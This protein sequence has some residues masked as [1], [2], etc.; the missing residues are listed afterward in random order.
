MAHL[1][2]DFMNETVND[3]QMEIDETSDDYWM[4]ILRFGE[5]WFWYEIVVKAFWMLLL[6]LAALDLLAFVFNETGLGYGEQAVMA[7]M[8]I[9]AG[10]LFAW[11][12]FTLIKLLGAWMFK[13]GWD[14][15]HR[16]ERFWK[17]RLKNVR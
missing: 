10:V 4:N 6:W 8:V 12:A 11:F 3:F 15:Y 5:T 2:R 16:E 7:G 13:V 1:I 9:F 17:E 14:M